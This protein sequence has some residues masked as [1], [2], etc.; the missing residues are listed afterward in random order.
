MCAGA[1]GAREAGI[2]EQHDHMG[3]PE[4]ARWQCAG[5][6]ATLTSQDTSSGAITDPAD[7]KVGITAA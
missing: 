3:E 4:H 5:W 7:C 1:H 2:S 6:L